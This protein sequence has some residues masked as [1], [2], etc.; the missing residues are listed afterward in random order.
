MYQIYESRQLTPN[1]EAAYKKTR[2]SI[3]AAL[4]ETRYHQ[5]TNWIGDVAED[6]FWNNHPEHHQKSEKYKITNHDGW[7]ISRDLP[8]EVKCC[9]GYQDWR[10]GFSLAVDY[11]QW[12]GDGR[13]HEY[14]IVIFHHYAFPTKRIATLG[15]CFWD[16]ANDHPSKTFYKRGEVAKNKWGTK[17]FDVKN[18][19]G[20]YVWED[21]ILQDMSKL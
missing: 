11:D 18:L 2:P 10:K 9:G 6:F 13:R 15:W 8:I 7:H 5:D 16:D 20:C 14:A 19:N 17:M 21:T 12:H 4:G 3:D 1:E